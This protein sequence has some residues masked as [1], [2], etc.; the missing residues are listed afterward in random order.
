MPLLWK[1]R[2]RRRRLQQGSRGQ[3]SRLQAQA[4][5]VQG[6]NKL[7]HKQLHRLRLA[8]TL[9]AV[10]KNSSDSTHPLFDPDSSTICLP[11]RTQLH[12][13]LDSIPPYPSSVPFVIRPQNQNY[14][15]LLRSDSAGLMGL[16][17]PDYRDGGRRDHPSD[18]REFT[19]TFLC[20]PARLFLLCSP[21]ISWLRQNN[22]LIDRSTNHTASV[23]QNT[24][25]QHP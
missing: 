13:L 21:R 2:T 22:P 23:L 9:P 6:F 15:C 14:I 17:T 3:G 7:I 16:V 25:V 5:G 20:N 1:T 4:D 10:A 8:L 19:L 24:E 18:R 11:S 12:P